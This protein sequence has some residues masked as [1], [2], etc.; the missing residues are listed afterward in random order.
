MGMER[1]LAIV[2]P[3]A[4][5]RHLIGKIVSRIES[6]GLR[7]VAMKMLRLTPEDARR[8][9]IVHKERPFY[10]SLTRF[11]SSGPVVVLALEGENA[12]AKWRDLMGATNPKDAARDTIRNDFGLDVEK[13]STHGSD[14]PETGKT[15]LAFFFN[16]L[17]T[18]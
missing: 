12:I 15:E 2:K 7:P 3:D 5:E 8:F 4:V 10:D 11:M 13:N 9:Y 18:V 1:T 6:G 16:A 14:S 17:E